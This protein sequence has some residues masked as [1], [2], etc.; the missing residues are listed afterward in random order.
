MCLILIFITGHYHYL[1]QLSILTTFTPE[2]FKV[3][4]T[5]REMTV[6]DIKTTVKDFQNAAKRRKAGFD[7]VEIHSSNGYLFQQFF[8]GRLIIEQMNT[9]EVLKTKPVSF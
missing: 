4:V 2:G 6:E 7:G 9:V 1:R 3:T 8:N 5:P